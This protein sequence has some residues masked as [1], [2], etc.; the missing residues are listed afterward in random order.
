MIWSFFTITIYGYPFD[1]PQFCPQALVTDPSWLRPEPH[2]LRHFNWCIKYI[3]ILLYTN[4]IF[5]KVK[6]M[7]VRG[8]DINRHSD[9]RRE[10]HYISSRNEGSKASYQPFEDI[11]I[12]HKYITTYSLAIIKRCYILI[13]VLCLCVYLLHMPSS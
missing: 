5:L 8:D 12:D 7:F 2:Y 1:T 3:T 4:T 13:A 11:F 9:G 6:I 10:G